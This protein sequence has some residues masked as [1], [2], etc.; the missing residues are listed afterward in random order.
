M[1]DYARTLMAQR[2]RR[3]SF[4]GGIQVELALKCKNLRHRDHFSPPDP[5]CIIF[6]KSRGSRQW[7][8]LGR[9]E[10]VKN[11][12]NPEWAKTFLV[13]FYF[14]EKQPSRWTV[15]GWGDERM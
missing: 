14:E 8:R 12:S 5:V 13:D 15:S 11:E 3:G 2:Q 10:M 7:K 6:I 4:V 1:A 9:T